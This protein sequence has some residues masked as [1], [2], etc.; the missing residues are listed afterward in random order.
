MLANLVIIVRCLIKWARYCT[1]QGREWNNE[2]RNSGWGGR[3]WSLVGNFKKLTYGLALKQ[4]E[5]DFRYNLRNGNRCPIFNMPGCRSRDSIVG[6]WLVFGC[7]FGV[8]RCVI[9]G[10]RDGKLK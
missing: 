3:I 10:L 2:E 6:C 9:F 4:F 7:W 5:P 1:I 8:L